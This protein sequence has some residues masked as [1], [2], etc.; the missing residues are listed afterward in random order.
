MRILQHLKNLIQSTSQ[1]TPK[2]TAPASYRVPT[3]KYDAQ[4]PHTWGQ[5][6]Y[7][8]FI[9]ALWTQEIS[10]SEPLC[11]AAYMTALQRCAEG[12]QEGST[13]F[14]YLHELH[15]LGR[16]QNIPWEHNPGFAEELDRL[17]SVNR[18]QAWYLCTGYPKDTP[19]LA[20]V[21]QEQ[22]SDDMY[23]VLSVSNNPFWQGKK[24]RPHGD[25]LYQC[26]AF[27]RIG[28]NRAYSRYEAG[29]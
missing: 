26:A 19:W 3:T 22:S 4:D 7:V 10:I 11:Q 29:P 23:K 21:L 2:D 20:R 16:A 13:Y 18:E 27:S 28:K 25:V 6:A 9:S 17:F 15:T 24:S 1:V 12:S 5:D 14:S 8:G